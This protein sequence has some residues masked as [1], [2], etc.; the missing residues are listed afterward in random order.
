MFAYG[1]KRNTYYLEMN[2]ALSKQDGVTHVDSWYSDFER[3]FLADRHLQQPERTDGPIDENEALEFIC[4]EGKFATGKFGPY[5]TN[6]RGGGNTGGPEWGCEEF[7]KDP[8]I[9]NR[10]PLSWIKLAEITFMQPFGSEERFAQ[11][12]AFRTAVNA[13]REKVQSKAKGMG[14]GTV[15]ER[16][17]ALHCGGFDKI[18]TVML[19]SVFLSVYGVFAALLILVPIP[20][21][22]FCVGNLFIC[23]A[24]ILGFVHWTGQTY[25]AVTNSIC[26]LSVGLCVD[27]S[28]HIAHVFLHSR[29]SK[30]ERM[31]H[32]LVEIGP[33]IFN[34]GMTSIIGVIVFAG[35]PSASMRAFCYLSVLTIIF[36]LFQGLMVLPSILL[37]VG[38]KITQKSGMAGP[39]GLAFLPVLLFVMDCSW[40]LKGKV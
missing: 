35:M 39:A 27:Y 28:V 20:S 37:M 21:A 15:A 9:V 31:H 14:Q 32:A 24:N 4:R 34:G 22:I 23:V 6:I 2:S 11:Y 13:P 3:D 16:T 7:S 40:C 12:D 26:V 29:G 5:A 8:S 36:G 17:F 38:D 18:K 19:Q 33:S 10:Y 30:A 1:L 25:N